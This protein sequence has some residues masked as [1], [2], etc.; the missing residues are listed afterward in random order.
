MSLSQISDELKIE[1]RGA[2]TSS[3]GYGSAES[4]SLIESS[5]SQNVE[6]SDTTPL[7]YDQSPKKKKAAVFDERSQSDAHFNKKKSVTTSRQ[8]IEVS[9]VTSAP[10]F[11]DAAV[12]FRQEPPK[13]VNEDHLLWVEKWKPQTSKKIIGQQGEKSNVNKLT[14]WLNNWYKNNTGSKKA[15]FVPSK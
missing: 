13:V 8:K 3:S 9:A 10:K 4:Q 12:S 5:D 11:A 15:V 2:D 14:A 6:S 7:T 1:L